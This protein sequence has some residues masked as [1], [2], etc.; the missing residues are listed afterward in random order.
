[1]VVLS[2]PPER[3]SVLE[4]AVTLSHESRH[5]RVGAGGQYET[6]PH[7]GEGTPGLCR[8]RIYLGDQELRRK[9]ARAVSRPSAA[10]NIGESAV[11]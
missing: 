11:K 5:Y 6:V 10:G 9:L 2:I 8:D 7:V 3:L 4:L 1:V